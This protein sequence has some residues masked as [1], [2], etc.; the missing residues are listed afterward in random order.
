MQHDDMTY[1]Y[2]IARD[3]KVCQEPAVLEYS[4]DF[5]ESVSVYVVIVQS[6]HLNGALATHQ[7]LNADEGDIYIYMRESRI[8]ETHRR[9]CTTM[10]REYK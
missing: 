9:I 10:K 1:P 4:S 8:R 5:L 6:K 2:R 7:G 3:G